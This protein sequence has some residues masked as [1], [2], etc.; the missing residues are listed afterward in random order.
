MSPY[1]FTLGTVLSAVILFAGHM[2][3]WIGLYN[4]W[5][6]TG[7]PRHAVRGLSLATLVMMLLSGAAPAAWL[8]LRAPSFPAITDRFEGALFLVWAVACCLLFLVVT[9]RWALRR[10]FIRPQARLLSNATS[11]LNIRAQ[12]GDRAVGDKTIRIAAC[13]PG[14]QILDVST[15]TKLLSIAEL[16]ASLE[17]LRI[18]HLSD[19]HMA[20][21]LTPTFFD[22]AVDQVNELNADLVT[23]T[24]DIV[25]KWSCIKWIPKTLGR[26]TSR[27][28]NFFVLGNHDR[29]V[30]DVGYL[31]ST[32]TGCG[33]E[34]LGGNC[35]LRS[36]RGQKVLLAGNERP[37]FQQIPSISQR[38]NEQRQF[39]IALSHSPDQLPWAR[40]HRFDL[41]LAGHTHGGQIRFPLIGPIVCPSRSGVWY[42]S[43]LFDAPP[44]L[45][46]VSR[47]L[48]GLFP[49]R[50]N[51]RPEI[52]LLELR[53]QA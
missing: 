32:L 44:T 5:H 50:L 37:W 27:F 49:V 42:A 24:G 46:H 53:R 29:R 16:P 39:S 19:L 3:F 7:L 17:G 20:G 2:A 43:G 30:P 23:I 6:G 4:R 38:D 14:N 51:C 25:D 21:Q 33:L 35:V 45:M 13:I 40:E 48:S 18:A 47:G 28:G 9:T 36:I 22:A 26:L 11:S 10:W 31:R 12:V 1:L 8:A 34:D 41:L 52:S 15:Q